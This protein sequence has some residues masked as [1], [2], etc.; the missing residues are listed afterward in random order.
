VARALSTDP[1]NDI[2][3]KIFHEIIAGR[4]FCGGGFL[5][6]GGG[7][8]V[9]HAQLRNP[10]GSGKNLYIWKHSTVGGVYITDYTTA[11]SS[12]ITS[13]S[14]FNLNRG[15]S[16]TPVAQLR[17]ENNATPLGTNLGDNRAFPAWNRSPAL[18]IVIP[19]QALSFRLDNANSP[20]FGQFLWWEE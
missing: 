12:D 11:M 8:I 5:A 19:G 7:G 6:A 13:T 17:V 3:S 16:I 20:F 14:V 1:K 15:S 2:F 9:S 18:I 4:A 10:T